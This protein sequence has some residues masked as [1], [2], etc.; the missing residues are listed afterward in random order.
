MAVEIRILSGARQDERI[1]FDKT[2][3]RA[4]SSPECEIF[5]DPQA[6]TG[7][8]NRS[9]SFQLLEDG[10]YI[11]HSMGVILVNQRTVSRTDTDSC[12]RRGADVGNR[13]GLFLQH[14]VKYR[15]QADEI[16]RTRGHQSRSRDQWPLLYRLPQGRPLPSHASPAPIPAPSVT[17][18]ISAGLNTA[19]AGINERWIL[20]G[21]GGGCGLCDPGISVCGPT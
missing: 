19:K 18:P 13:A 6:D 7:T 21:A 14:R 5:F 2:N 17:E 12:G 1:V 15:S 4:G 16:I 20:W 8:I 9:A 11:S 10:W 3:F